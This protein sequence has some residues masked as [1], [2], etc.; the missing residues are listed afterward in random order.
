MK[1][2]DII[3]LLEETSVHSDSSSNDMV[4]LGE[5]FDYLADEL[6]NQQRELLIAYN[7]SVIRDSAWD[8]SKNEIIKNI[9]NFLK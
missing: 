4:I 8:V 1:K 9:D 6:I 7:K 5:D 2:E 3:K